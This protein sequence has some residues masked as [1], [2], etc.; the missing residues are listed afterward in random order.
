MVSAGW[1]PELQKLEGHTS[2]VRAV[3]FSQDGSLL[4][5]ASHDQTVRLW[6][7]TTGQEVQKLEGHTRWVSAV[8]FSQDGSLLAS[9][10]YDQIV[11]LWNPTTGQEVQRLENGPQIETIS[12]TSNN[13]TW[14]TNCGILYVDEGHYSGVVPEYDSNNT[15]MLRGGWIR[16]DS[17]NLLWLPQDYRGCCSAFYNNTCAIGQFSGQ[18]S[19]IQLVYSE[20]S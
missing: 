13:M 15:T 5:S 1:G 16:Q 17:R 14:L 3:A 19:F 11:R 2:W 10:S 18:V 20:R 8:A 7:P 9:A 6:N 4:A 12:P